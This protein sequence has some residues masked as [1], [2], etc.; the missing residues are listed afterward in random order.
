MMEHDGSDKA[1]RIIDDSA[2]LV[3]FPCATDGK[4]VKNLFAASSCNSS[5]FYG[6]ALI[7]GCVLPRL[8]IVSLSIR[9]LRHDGF[10]AVEGSPIDDSRVVVRY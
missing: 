2:E 3:Y 10:C 4:H 8:G 9:G 5:W 1:R 6:V 7:L